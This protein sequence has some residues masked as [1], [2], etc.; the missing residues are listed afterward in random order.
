MPA[1][2]TPPRSFFLSTPTSAWMAAAESSE[3]ATSS[4]L[5]ETHSQL[6]SVTQVN[7]SAKTLKFSPEFVQSELNRLQ[8]HRNS[9]EV[10]N[11]STSIY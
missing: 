2:E 5:L 11:L 10:H 6:A 8:L 7:A 3:D 4:S 1:L 9:A